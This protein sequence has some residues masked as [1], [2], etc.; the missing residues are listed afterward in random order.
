M[1]KEKEVTTAPATNAAAP[2]AAGT[3]P[4]F[5][6]KRRRK[7]CEFC[8][9]NIEKIDYKDSARLK[10]FV[11]ERAKIYPRRMTGTCA[12]H[13]RELVEAIKRA[14]QMALLPYISD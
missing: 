9:G 13:Q 8:V 3:K 10:K 12:K 6:P 4:P 1:D 5:R 11:S 7:V 2:A 14:R